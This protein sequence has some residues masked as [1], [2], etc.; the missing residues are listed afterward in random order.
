LILS[1][2]IVL[3][4]GVLVF[5]LIRYSALRAWQAAACALFGFYLASSPVAPY[6]RTAAT[7]IAHLI[8]GITL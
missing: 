3:L 2:S 8:S 6:I 4:L 5:V 1:A 7:A